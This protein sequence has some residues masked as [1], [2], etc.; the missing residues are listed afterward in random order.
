MTSRPV[1]RRR[2]WCRVTSGPSSP[3]AEVLDTWGAACRVVDT[4]LLKVEALW[5]GTAYEA[6]REARL[7]QSA[8]WRAADTAFSGAAAAVDTYR[9]ALVGGR[10]SAEYARTLYDTGL[11]KQAAAQ[12]NARRQRAEMRAQGI[13]VYV[14]PNTTA[15]TSEMERAVTVLE[16]A[17]AEVRAAG[18]TAARALEAAELP[19]SR[20]G[21]RRYE[22]HGGCPRWRGSSSRTGA[23]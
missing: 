17:R 16:V 5:T 10:A 4:G 14:E 18:E 11:E 23:P 20:C 1:C 19:R 22:G 15:G 13:R 21:S 3:P 6:W 8:K 2:S 7:E 9:R 12:E